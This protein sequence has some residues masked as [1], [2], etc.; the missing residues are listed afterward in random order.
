L[1]KKR[2]PP[3]IDEAKATIEW[4]EEGEIKKVNEKK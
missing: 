4:E 2:M 1:L 3:S